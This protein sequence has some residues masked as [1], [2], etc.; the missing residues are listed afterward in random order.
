MRVNINFPG[1]SIKT[2]DGDYNN[3]II[4]D[5]NSNIYAT[6]QIKY[7]LDKY[8][9]LIINGKFPL[10]LL[11]A[12]YLEPKYDKFINHYEKQGYTAAPK[13]KIIGIIQKLDSQLLVFNDISNKDI[14]L[15]TLYKSGDI[16]PVNS[17]MPLEGFLSKDD[18][19]NDIKSKIKKNAPVY[20]Y[21]LKP[22]Q[23]QL[24]NGK[25]LATQPLYP[26]NEESILLSD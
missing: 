8:S 3:K 10:N 20:I 13:N 4:L 7:Y 15:A 12:K 5:I 18:A 6:N 9:E 25:L 21:K 14:Y 17:K 1:I 22:E 2:S 24:M 11:N 16:I 23:F 19:I 26:F